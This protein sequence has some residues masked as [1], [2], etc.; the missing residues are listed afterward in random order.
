MKPEQY[1]KKL[2]DKS[3]KKE[4]K[5]FRTNLKKNIEKGIREDID[6]GFTFEE[7]ILSISFKAMEKGYPRA[8]ILIIYKWVEDE[9]K[10]YTKESK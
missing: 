4:L 8:L 1:L 7:I 2:I 9:Y 5:E 3:N 10:R 6:R